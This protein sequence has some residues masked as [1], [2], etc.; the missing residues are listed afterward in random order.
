MYNHII[1]IT[2]FLSLFKII[3]TTFRRSQVI[4]LQQSVKEESLIEIESLTDLTRVQTAKGG[5][6]L[7]LNI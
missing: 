1:T 6:Y 5:K 4:A 3:T 7:F 2:Y